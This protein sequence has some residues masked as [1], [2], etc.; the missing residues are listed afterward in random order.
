M[1]VQVPSSAPQK[2]LQSARLFCFA[3][4]GLSPKGSAFRLRSTGAGVK[5]CPFLL[6]SGYQQLFHTQKP[7][8]PLP[9]KS[10][11]K[12]KAFLFCYSGTFTQRFGVPLCSTG[13][14]IK[15][16][17]FLLKNCHRQLFYTQ[18]PLHPLPVKS[19]AKRTASSFCYSGYS[20][21]GFF[22]LLFRDFHPRVRRLCLR[23]TGAGEMLVVRYNLRHYFICTIKHNAFCNALYQTNV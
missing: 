17:P 3:I 23:S 8:H 22:V 5:H 11:A 10:L 1:G 14:G 6:K 20:A 16:C 19:L 2:A 4:Q 18:K 13:A 9:V 7:L 15:H 12:R 21:Q